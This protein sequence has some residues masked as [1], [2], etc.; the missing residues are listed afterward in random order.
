VDVLSYYDEDSASLSATLT[1]NNVPVD[2]EVVSFEVRKQSDDSLVETLTGTTNSQGVATVSYDSKGVGDLNVHCEA[3]QGS[4]VSEICEVQDC[5][6]AYPEETSFTSTWTSDHFMNIFNLNLN[7]PSNFK[8]E[9]EYKG[10]IKHGRFGLIP[11]NNTS[12][13]PNYSLFVQINTNDYV[14]VYRSTSTSG[15]DSGRLSAD[16]TQY[17]NCQIIKDGNTCTWVLGGTNTASASIT[18]VDSHNPYT[19][20]A[21]VYNL[22]TNYLKNITIKPL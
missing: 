10:N 16:N 6:F 19:L 3:L 8:L 1:D 5:I 20:G 4:L 17:H 21:G 7:L 12:G 18:W 2:G 9:F 15:L 22:G 14:G 11:S 13:N